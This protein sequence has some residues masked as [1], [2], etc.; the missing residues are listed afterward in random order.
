MTLPH[1]TQ[2]TEPSLCSSVETLSEMRRL[3]LQV[4]EVSIGRGWG[5]CPDFLRFTMDLPTR[6][7]VQGNN[8]TAKKRGTTHYDLEETAA[9]RN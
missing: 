7:S 6:T 1:S 9:L 3:C 8:Y 2:R 5:A 4:E